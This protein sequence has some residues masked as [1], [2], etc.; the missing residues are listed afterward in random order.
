M[1][2]LFPRARRAG[3]RGAGEGGSWLIGDPAHFHGPAAHIRLAGQV[4]G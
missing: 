1:I 2:G 4:W 3:F